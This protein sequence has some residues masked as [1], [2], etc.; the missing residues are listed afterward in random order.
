MGIGVGRLHIHYLRGKFY[1]LHFLADKYE[2]IIS[3]Y[4]THD[5]NPVSLR[6]SVAD[7]NTTRRFFL[8]L[9]L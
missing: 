4:E 2:N 5:L 8:C 6:A 3:K 1:G 7:E 9:R